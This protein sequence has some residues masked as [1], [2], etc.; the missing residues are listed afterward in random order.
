[1]F[2]YVCITNRRLCKDDFLF[3]IREI[4]A[5][6]V[7]MIILREKD[8]SAE[9]Y[10]A[11]AQ[12]VLNACKGFEEKLVI[13]GRPEAA[14]KLGISK[15][16]MPLNML[17]DN[18]CVSDGFKKVGTSIHSAEQLN[19]AEK[20][21]ADYVIAGH[22]FETK[23]KENMPPRGIGFLRDI[24]ERSKLPVYA[25]GGITPKN[26]KKLADLGI[27]NLKGVCMMS[28]FAE[29]VKISE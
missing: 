10:L 26:A 19:T 23:C 29:K 21:G 27:A 6:D 3:R 12:R 9:A 2:D 11:L 5:T 7:A 15:I 4:A 25:I 8:L 13:H 20:L 24:C 18:P 16:H 28:Y 14:K 1:M 17:S 22:I